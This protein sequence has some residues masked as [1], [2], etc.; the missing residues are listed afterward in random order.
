MYDKDICCLTA[1]SGPGWEKVTSMKL[2]KSIMIHVIAYSTMFKRLRVV[3][4]H[5][6]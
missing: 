5:L 6:T 3:A 2:V 1:H 4:M